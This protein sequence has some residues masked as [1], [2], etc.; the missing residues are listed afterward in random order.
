VIRE[1]L[2]SKEAVRLATIGIG[3]GATFFG[4]VPMFAPRFFCRSFGLPIED[5][6]AADVIV[7]SVSSRDIINGIGIISAAMHGGR[8]GPWLIARAVADGTDAGTIAIAFA[9]GA[10]G[11]RFGLLGALAAGGTV[12][13]LVLYRA[14]KSIAVA[15]KTGSAG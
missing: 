15:G 6:P 2:S 9:S 5:S 7:R 11:W 12:A 3:I 14:N 4:L 10:R 8:V 1:V 13:D